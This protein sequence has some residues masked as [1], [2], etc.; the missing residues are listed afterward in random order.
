M[1]RLLRVSSTGYCQWRGRAPSPRSNARTALDVQIAAIHAQSR[2][3]CGR[4]WIVGQLHTQGL[5]PGHER[6]RRSLLRQK[7]RPVYR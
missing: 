7:L 4:E 1:Y 2:R 6:V 3:S 5:R